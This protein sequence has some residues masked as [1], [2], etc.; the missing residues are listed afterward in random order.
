MR[1]VDTSLAQAKVAT[2]R[3]A[4]IERIHRENG[5]LALTVSVIISA[6]YLSLSR[7]GVERFIL[8]VFPA[9][10]EKQ[11]LRIYERSRSRIGKAGAV[12]GDDESYA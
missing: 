3:A 4:E 7:D 5:S 2:D 6:F 11:A 1:N 10:S 8:A 9:D 12:V